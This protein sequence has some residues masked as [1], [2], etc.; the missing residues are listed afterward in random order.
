MA[1][2]LANFL[3]NLSQP[4]YQIPITKIC[5]IPVKVWIYKTKRELRLSII[6]D[7]FISNCETRENHVGVYGRRAY[8]F[9][10]IDE[11]TYEKFAKIV[12][13]D[14][15]N[16]RFDK[17]TGKF[18]LPK[19]ISEEPYIFEKLWNMP[20]IEMKYDECCVCH[21]KTKVKSKCNHTLCIECWLQ[22]PETPLPDNPTDYDYTIQPCPICRQKLQYIQ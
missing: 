7:I 14:L 17:Y 4:F 15:E 22:V 10:T 1:T 3:C 20:H 5:E 19:S 9:P 12:L 2:Q 11:E 8:K 13:D 6:V 18:K 21:E 16:I